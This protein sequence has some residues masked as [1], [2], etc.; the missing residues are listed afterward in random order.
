MKASTVLAMEVHGNNGRIGIADQFCGKGGP[1]GIHNTAKTLAI[2]GGNQP[3]WK[4]KNR[5]VLV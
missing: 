4:N 1:R 2:C 5:N 3:R